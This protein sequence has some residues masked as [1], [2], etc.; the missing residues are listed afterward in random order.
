MWPAVRW[1]DD[2]LHLCHVEELRPLGRGDSAQRHHHGRPFDQRE[3]ERTGPRAVV[4]LE[5]DHLPR[6]DGR[7]VE[8]SVPGIRRRQE[9]RVRG[10]LVAPDDR[11]AISPAPQPLT[12]PLGRHPMPP[13]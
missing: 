1:R 4:P 5:R 7:G 8:L 9:F 13:K 10:L 2:R 6:A 3:K 11:G 12:Q